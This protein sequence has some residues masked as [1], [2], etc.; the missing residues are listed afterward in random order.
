MGRIPHGRG[1]QKNVV[2]ME[3]HRQLIAFLFQRSGKK[4][5]DDNEMYMALSY[6]LGWFTPAQ[7]RDFIK[8]CLEEGLLKREGDAYIPNFEYGSMEIP[9]GFKVDGKEVMAGEKENVPPIIREITKR[10]VGEG[11]IRKI[12]EKENIIPEVAALIVAAENGINVSP[13]LRDVWDIIKNM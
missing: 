9:L 5:M 10:G 13:F 12:A 8:D 4:T 3:K 7:S 6:E 2:K 1:G 11:E